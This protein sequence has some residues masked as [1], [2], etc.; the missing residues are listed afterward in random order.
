MFNADSIS[1]IKTEVLAVMIARDFG[2]DADATEV[3]TA[4]VEFI[5]TG[6]GAYESY[7]SRREAWN[8]FV[9]FAREEEGDEADAQTETV[10]GYVTTQSTVEAAHMATVLTADKQMGLF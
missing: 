8:D 6:F 1:L 2:E 4:F 10:V 3:E 7:S 5:T 9:E